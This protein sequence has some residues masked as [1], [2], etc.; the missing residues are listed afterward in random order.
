VGTV[1]FTSKKDK[2]KYITFSTHKNTVDVTH[3]LDTDEIKELSSTFM[4]P[5][6]VPKPNGKLSLKVVVSST[7]PDNNELLH[8]LH[9]L[10]K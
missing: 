2:K 5:L 4:P 8:Q 9:N 6:E 1:I 10:G 3:D 7:E